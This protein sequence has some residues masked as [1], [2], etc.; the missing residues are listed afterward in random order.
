VAEV[1]NRGVDSLRTFACLY[2][3]VYINHTYFLRVCVCVCVS[4]HG[5]ASSGRSA[6]QGG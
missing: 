2:L 1:H 6:R 5:G 3:H 4:E